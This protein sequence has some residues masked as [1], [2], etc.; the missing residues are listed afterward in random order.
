MRY[1]A[2]VGMC[3]ALFT[4]CGTWAIAGGAEEEAAPKPEAQNDYEQ[5]VK[6][7]RDQLNLVTRELLKMERKYRDDP[8]VAEARK[9]MEQAREAY[10]NVLQEK[11]AADPEGKDLYARRDE[12]SQR[13]LELKLQHMETQEKKAKPEHTGGDE[14]R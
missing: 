11:I 10:Q 8:E 14:A 1:L 9:K 7:V 12:L 4:V 3:V 13:L 2:V 6:E 5:M